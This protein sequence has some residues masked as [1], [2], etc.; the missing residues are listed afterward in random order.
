MK[1]TAVVATLALGLLAATVALAGAPQFNANQGIQ[2]NYVEVRS[3]DVYV[4]QCFANGE[5]GVNGK[6]ATMAWQITNGSWNGI[7]LDGLSVIAVIHANATL[8]QTTANPY[9]T[10]AVVIVDEKA[11][12]SQRIA[13]VAF[14]D[15]QAGDLVEDISRVEVSPISFSPMNCGHEEC[16]SV[17]AGNILEISTR[18]LHDHDKHCGNEAAFYPPL[19]KIDG[20]MLHFAQRDMFAGEGLGMTWDNSVRSSAYMGTFSR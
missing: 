5:M 13:L 16:A 2:G 14:A 10:R 17:K 8:G 18:C 3:C 6:Q 19:T 7:N 20:A 1:R 12:E 9:P 4:A 11:N 15:T